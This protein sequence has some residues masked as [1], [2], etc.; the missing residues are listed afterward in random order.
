MSEQKPEYK[1]NGPKPTQ[2]TN[3]V[4]DDVLLAMLEEVL[5]K[6]RGAGWV[7]IK[8]DGV[9]SNSKRRWASVYITGTTGKSVIGVDATG[10]IT[11]DDM[12]VTGIKQ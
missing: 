11:L 12:P 7:V 10:L 2:N 1:T 3:T 8:R 9:A 4:P 6:L 5:S